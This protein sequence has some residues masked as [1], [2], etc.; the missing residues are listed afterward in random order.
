MIDI[1]FYLECLELSLL[2]SYSILFKIFF[3]EMLRI[4][5]TKTEIS[6]FR[7]VE[8]YKAVCKGNGKKFNRLKCE[9]DI[10]LLI[11]NGTLIKNNS[12]QTYNFVM[13]PKKLYDIIVESLKQARIP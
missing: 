7:V 10:K 6:V 13:S 3:L 11:S 12:E 2:E 9:K 5:G 8:I 1:E 4:S